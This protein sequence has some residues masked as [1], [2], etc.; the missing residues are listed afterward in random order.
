VPGKRQVTPTP[1]DPTS[2]IVRALDYAEGQRTRKS[3]RFAS[4]GSVRRTSAGWRVVPLQQVFCGVPVLHGVRAVRFDPKGRPVAFTGSSIDVAD[5]VP[6]LP[7]THPT[8]AARVA[9]LELA[10]AGA[11]ADHLAFTAA[12][13]ESVAELGLPS[14]PTVM[15]KAPLDDAI[16]ASLIVDASGRKARLLWE[17]RFRLPAGG[18]SYLVRVDASGPAVVP[19]VQEVVRASSHAVWGT[20]FE[21]DPGTPAAR[22]PFPRPAAHYPSIPSP[23]RPSGAWVE[24]QETRGNNADARTPGGGR[25]QG[26]PVGSDLVFEADADPG[27]PLDGAA[28]NAFYCCNF[29]HDFFYVLGFDE[30]AGNF[31]QVNEDGS[32][33]AGDPV[34]VL[35]QAGELPGLAFFDSRTDGN[36]PTMELGRHVSGRHTA[37]DGHVVTHEFAHGV[38]NRVVGAE[39]H[40][41]TPLQHQQS[42]AL[43]EGVSDYWAISIQNYYRRRAAR[44]AGTDPAGAEEWCF[45]S[46]LAGGPPGLR[47]RSYLDYDQ[48]YR[49]LKKSKMDATTAGEVWCATLLDLNRA[50]GQ[51]DA[52][53]GDELGWKLVFDSLAFLHPGEKGPHFLHARNAVLCAFDALVA[54]GTLGAD[55]REA[56]LEVFQRRGMGGDATSRNARFKSAEEG[57]GPIDNAY[58]KDCT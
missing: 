35:I 53:R 4:L 32:P 10:R 27:D 37:F 39:G 38:T 19:T 24:G 8:E 11:L 9:F 22:V 15:H 6:I 56:V 42:R 13:P 52:D 43:G 54:A 3:E 45:A 51:G 58:R 31:Q 57:F 34:G 33:G 46:W 26:R 18:G 40:L 28:V 21:F 41:H 36:Q 29:L 7:S 20:V 55:L 14:R 49:F 17:I 5:D 16:V 30:V 48:T 23:H 44:D 50:L 25:V 2:F 12:R 1:A 47:T